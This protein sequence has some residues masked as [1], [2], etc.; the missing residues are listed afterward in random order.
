[1]TTILGVSSDWQFDLSQVC[2]ESQTPISNPSGIEAAA[3]E[4]IQT[5]NDLIVLLEV[6]E[7]LGG[8]DQEIEAVSSREP[9]DARVAFRLIRALSTAE[10]ETAFERYLSAL[11]A[12]LGD[13]GIVG[14]FRTPIQ[15]RFDLYQAA[16]EQ[17]EGLN[18]SQER[19]ATLMGLEREQP[20]DLRDVRKT[21][22]ALDAL[23][24]VMRT[25]LEIAETV[26]P[27]GLQ[28][29]IADRCQAGVVAAALPVLQPP[30]PVEPVPVPGQPEPVPEADP[31]ETGRP[32]RDWVDIYSRLD[33]FYNYSSLND[34]EDNLLGLG[35]LVE[36]DLNVSENNAIGLVFGTS[37]SREIGY[38]IGERRVNDIFAGFL[39]RHRFDNW[40]MSLSANFF[41]FQREV[42]T[43][44]NGQSHAHRSTE[45]LLGEL[46]FG[47]ATED[48]H[49]W[50]EVSGLAGDAFGGMLRLGT[51]WQ[52][53]RS[54][55]NFFADG[56]VLAADSGLEVR[57]GAVGS[58]D[59]DFATI[60]RLG[61]AFGMGIFIRGEYGLVEDEN[62]FSA[63]AGLR[64]FIADSSFNPIRMP[65][66]QG[67][68]NE[69]NSS[70]NGR[71]TAPFSSA[72]D[73]SRK[74]GQ[75]FQNRCLGH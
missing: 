34:L 58:F 6:R 17:L 37:S 69:T 10:G 57:A 61:S 71:Q 13:S 36:F 18:F 35:G 49:F 59:L 75:S 64:L 42:D 45:H 3:Q 50:G 32:F 55:L 66:G 40:S 9:M 29:M 22:N 27:E 4:E 47:F 11:S 72:R 74:R 41:G 7:I 14:A 54:R 25:E 51:F 73:S 21:I 5:I 70:D 39:F 65:W 16:A 8:L 12:L 62:M 33:G 26:D 48:N 24:T 68:T 19:L 38:Y 52:L 31:P 53:G 46:R 63:I 28:A 67:L 15:S 30:P 1:M 56:S 60:P 43:E 2:Q 20:A 23:I 44:F